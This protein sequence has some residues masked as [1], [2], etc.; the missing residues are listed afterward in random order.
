MN[1]K[2]SR[3]WR[4]KKSFEG[5]W[6]YHYTASARRYFEAWAANAM[7]SRLEPVKKVVRMLRRH[8]QGLL[9]YARHHISNAAAEGFNSSIQTIK[10]NAR[11]FRN[12]QNYRIR[13]LFYCGKL[14]MLPA[15]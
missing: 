2:T 11:G 12:F 6:S 7:R 9:N 15:I 10:A 4:I 5:F 3:S 1:L 13:I 8:L 14:D